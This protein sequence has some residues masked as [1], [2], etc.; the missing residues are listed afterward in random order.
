MASDDPGGTATGRRSRTKLRRQKLIADAAARLLLSHSFEEITTRQVAAEAGVSEATLFRYISSKQ[1]LLTIVYGDQLDALLNEIENA[2]AEHQSQMRGKTQTSEHY[3]DRV[4]EVYKTRTD[5][6]LI[7]P[8]NAALYLREGFNP[9]SS[10]SPRHLAQGDRTIRFVTQILNDG[11]K[12]GLFIP[13]IDMQLIAQNL[14]GTYMHEIDR[15]PVRGYDPKTLWKRLAPRLRV[16]IEP[17]AN[18]GRAH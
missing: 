9:E 12:S 11:Q 18:Q 7:N 6:Y 16:Q 4:I 15:T 13:N 1:E 10:E 5:F 3:L 2:D 17:L 14:H 8:V